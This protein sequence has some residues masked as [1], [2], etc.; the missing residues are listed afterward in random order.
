MRCVLFRQ[1]CSVAGE[2]TL[3]NCNNIET[4]I[5]LTHVPPSI[6]TRNVL[7]EHKDFICVALRHVF[8]NCNLISYYYKGCGY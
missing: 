1:H 3:K 5:V 2:A 8:F 6:I 4:E 7:S